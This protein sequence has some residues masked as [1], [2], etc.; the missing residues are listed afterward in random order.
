MKWFQERGHHVTGIDRS[1][2]ALVTASQWGR[3]VEA[4]LEQGTWPLQSHQPSPLPSIFDAVVVCNYLWRPLFPSL[5]ASVRPG[6]WVFYE[7]FS[8][9]QASIGRPSNP[10]FLLQPKEL[11]TLFAGFNVMA[12]EDTYLDHPARFVQR[13]VAT[14]RLNM[15]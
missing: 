13:I 12:Y 2:A 9:Q 10:D 14:H 8:A 6:G 4:D 7:T 11:L 15:G 5:R 1:A 3:V